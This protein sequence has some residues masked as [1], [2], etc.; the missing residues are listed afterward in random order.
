MMKVCV[1]YSFCGVNAPDVFTRVNHYYDW[2]RE[3]IDQS[4]VA[5]AVAKEHLIDNDS[6]G[7]L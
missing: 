5:G 2:I 7:C 6:G 1:F 4:I 3:I